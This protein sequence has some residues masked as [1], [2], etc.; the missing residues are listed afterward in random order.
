MTKKQVLNSLADLSNATTRHEVTIQ[1]IVDVLPQQAKYKVLS[2]LVGSISCRVVGMAN[3]IVAQ[4]EGQDVE[5]YTLSPLEVLHMMQEPD[6]RMDRLHTA[7]MLMRVR[8]NYLAQFLEVANDS[9]RD[10]WSGTID[11]MSTPS[12][13]SRIDTDRLSVALEASELDGESAELVVASTLANE[14][15]RAIRSADQI[16]RRRGAIEWLIDHVLSSTEYYDGDGRPATDTNTD[17]DIESLPQQIVESMHDKFIKIMTE[18]RKS[19]V[20]NYASNSFDV[21]LDDVVLMSSL[22]KQCKE[23]KAHYNDEVNV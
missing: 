6:F 5:F 9:A 2:S 12:T 11:L 16:S 20:D 10:S 23:L 22:I 1:H 7:R 17:S 15:T 19:I 14:K 18:A 13:V 3:S 8:N 4:L 21:T